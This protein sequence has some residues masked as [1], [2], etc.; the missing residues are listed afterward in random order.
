MEQGLSSGQVGAISSTYDRTSKP[1]IIRSLNSL[2]A[3]YDQLTIA[4][5]DCRMLDIDKQ[6]VYNEQG[7]ADSYR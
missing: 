6:Y 2:I 4:Y 5:G 1:G 7:E 3:R